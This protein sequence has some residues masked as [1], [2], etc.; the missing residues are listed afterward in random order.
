M[1]RFWKKKKKLNPLY[2]SSELANESVEAAFYEAARFFGYPNDYLLDYEW[3]RIHQAYNHPSRY[4]H[5]MNHVYEMLLMLDEHL[6][7]LDVI[8][9]NN[10]YVLMLAIIYHDFYNGVKDAENKSAFEATIYYYLKA[11]KPTM[12]NGELLGEAIRATQ[13]HQSDNI[14]IQWLI[15]F[16]LYRLT[17]PGDVWSPAIRLEYPQHSDKIFNAGRKAILEKFYNREPIFYHL[18]YKD[19][20]K[21]YNSLF[22]QIREL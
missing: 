15:D 9:E 16:D 2:K 5:N 1:L 13:D 14:L 10:Y 22:D 3:L 17:C 12:E 8:S 21:A 6:G 18:G 4:Y 19:N 11:K 7:D 20:L